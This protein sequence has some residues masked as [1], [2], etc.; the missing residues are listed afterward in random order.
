[1]SI[2]ENIEPLV[3]IHHVRSFFR[4]KTGRLTPPGDVPYLLH[5]IDFR[6]ENQTTNTIQPAKEQNIRGNITQRTRNGNKKR[7]ND[8]RRKLLM[9]K[10]YLVIVIARQDAYPFAIIARLGVGS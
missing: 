7:I 4:N 6:Q 3:Y 5:K 2:N 1:M 10:G 9:P 8:K